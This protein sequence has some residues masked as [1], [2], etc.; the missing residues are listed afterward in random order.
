MIS[1]SKSSLFVGGCDRCI[2]P[3]LNDCVRLY[4]R[5]V[6]IRFATEFS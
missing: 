6:A 5:G 1:G 2:R 4:E 3:D